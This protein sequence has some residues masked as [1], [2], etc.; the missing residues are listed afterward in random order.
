MVRIINDKMTDKV[1]IYNLEGHV[2]EEIQL[3]E[4]IM[5]IPN[6]RGCFSETGYYY[7]GSGIVYTNHLGCDKTYN[8]NGNGDS[9]L[10]PK[11][12]G[13]TDLIYENLLLCY[14]HLVGKFGIFPFRH[15][16]V[17][18]DLEGACGKKEK[19]IVEN[20]KEFNLCSIEELIEV[21][22]TG[23]EDT[24]IYCYK[25]KPV[26]GNVFDIVRLIE[27]VLES[28]WNTA[29]DKNVWGDLD[30]YGY[31]RD[32]ADWYKSDQFSHKLGTVFSL[33]N[34]LYSVDKVLYAKLLLE[35]L[36]TYDFGKKTMLLFSKEIVMKYCKSYIDT[37]YDVDVGEDW[38]KKLYMYLVLG[39]A[40]CHLEDDG[41]WDWVRNYYMNLYN[42]H[43]EKK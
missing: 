34:S 12:I 32:V 42:P 41:K 3:K 10:F 7:K 14:E 9:C 4:K 40:C 15:Q 11:V 38:F 43:S 28:D 33:L 17:F 31:V 2:I 26:K 37:E 25:L 27:Y 24:N 30:G 19:R 8:N 21:I 29:W 23:I 5:P 16:P 36:G 6:K 22:P 39:K 20:I 13:K 18:S 35:L 1:P